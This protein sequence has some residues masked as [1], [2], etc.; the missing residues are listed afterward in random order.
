[1]TTNVTDILSDLRATIDEIEESN[2]ALRVLQERKAE[3]EGSLL[4]MHETTGLEKLTGGGMSVSFGQKFRARYD[5]ER[6]AGVLRWAVDTGN[7]HIIQRRF[8]DSKVEELVMNGVALPEG[9][10]LEAYAAISTRRVN[11]AAT[12]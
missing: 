11:S 9:L 2:A 4:R 10:T 7:E 1:M 5:P 12:L 6:Y 8:T 3:L